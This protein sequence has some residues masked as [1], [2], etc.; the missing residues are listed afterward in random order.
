MIVA[1]PRAVPIPLPLIALGPSRL[2]LMNDSVI[3]ALARRVDSH[4]CILE[5]VWN[6]EESDHAA[7]D[8]DLV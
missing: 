1:R 2:N 5:H 4:W 3:A 7:P 6:D 8:V